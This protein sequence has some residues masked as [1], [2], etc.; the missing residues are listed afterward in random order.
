MWS[1]IICNIYQFTNDIEIK[2]LLDQVVF[3]LSFVEVFFFLLTLNEWTIL[4]SL[5][6]M[7]CPHEI[8]LGLY[9]C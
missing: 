8:A 5:M 9:V 3:H 7:I 1:F 4:E 2:L 6:D